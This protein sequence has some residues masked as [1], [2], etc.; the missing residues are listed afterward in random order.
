MAMGSVMAYTP[1]SQ[2][3]SVCPLAASP[4]LSFPS[5][6]VSRRQLFQPRVFVKRLASWQNRPST[7]QASDSLYMGI[8]VCQRYWL[9]CEFLGGEFYVYMS[10][11]SSF[12][13]KGL[14]DFHHRS[15]QLVG[16]LTACTKDSGMW[17][18]DLGP[19]VC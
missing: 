3:G 16:T 10:P 12:S 9:S 5:C 15:V 7:I 6:F 13:L 2:Y 19:I 11:L 17:S 18:M 1:G 4:A 8:I 14:G